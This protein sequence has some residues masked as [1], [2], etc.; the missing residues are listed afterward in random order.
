VPSFN[1]VERPWIPCVL[2]G[3]EAVQELGLRDVLLRAHEIRELRGSS[4]SV[5]AGLLRLLLAILHR[6]YDGPATVEAWQSM[7]ERGQF[8]R[9]VVG[10]YLELWAHRFDLFDSARPFYQTPDI[11]VSRAKPVGVLFP[12]TKVDN[13]AALFNRSVASP[14]WRISL[15]QAACQI[16]ATQAVALGGLITHQKHEPANPFKYS[17]AAPLANVAI[18]SVAGEQLFETLLLNLHAYDPEQDEP[19]PS[20]GQDRPA[21][22]REEPVG[23]SDRGPDGYLDLLTWQS[24][25]ILLRTDDAGEVNGACVMKGDSFPPGYQLQGKETMAAFRPRPRAKA[26]EPWEALRFVEDRALWRDSLTFISAEPGGPRP[27][28]L[29]WLAEVGLPRTERLRIRAL[30]MAS[31]QAKPLFHREEHLDLPAAFLAGGAALEDAV[32]AALRV[33]ED[34]GAL[35]GGGPIEWTVPSGKTVRGDAPLR[36]LALAVTGDA[37]RVRAFV[38]D[39][40]GGARVYWAALELPFQQLLV[41]L[42]ELATSERDDNGTIPPSAPPLARW[43]AELRSAAEDAFDVAVGG[44]LG[45]ARGVAAVGKAEAE[46][47]RHLGRILAPYEERKEV[48]T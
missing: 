40:L 43:A 25:R 2:D 36:Q 22:E 12:E 8:D 13:D 14:G 10:D 5:T 24:R 39:S 35:L 31:T 18:L 42:A 3:A 37:D 9:E 32:R 26:G 19:F 6:A 44:L 47:R 4:P 20:A 28:M 11:D 29:N 45:S 27:M 7:R 33:A 34:A 1:L 16:V 15:A 38:H 30:G 46:F 21:W 41:R 17:T 23:V 48:T